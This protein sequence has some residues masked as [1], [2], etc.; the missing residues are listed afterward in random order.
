MASKIAHLSELESV[1]CNNEKT[2]EGVLHFFSTFKTRRFL[3]SFGPF[4]SKGSDVS[5]LL[6]CLLIFRLRGESIYRMQNHGK[7]FLEKIDDNTFYRLMNNPWMDWR[8]Y[9]LRKINIRG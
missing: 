4:K 6:L 5:L 2:N 1:L 7:N 9:P 3:G 8:K